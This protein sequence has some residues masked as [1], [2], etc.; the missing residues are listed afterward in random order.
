[1]HT[2]SRRHKSDGRRFEG[3]GSTQATHHTSP[4][5][6]ESN[7][8][9]C[10]GVDSTQATYHARTQQHESNG[11]GC[12]GIH[13][14]SAELQRYRSLTE[15]RRWRNTSMQLEF[16]LQPMLTPEPPKSSIPTDSPHD[17]AGNI[18]VPPVLAPTRG[19]NT[20]N[21]VPRSGSLSTRINPPARSVT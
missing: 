7:G 8:C 1:H 15:S 9:G 16:Q 4:Q 11:C 20:R 12:E 2:L 6:H 18:A 14:D 10:E 17:S 19:K 21:V 13:G 3:V 5:Q